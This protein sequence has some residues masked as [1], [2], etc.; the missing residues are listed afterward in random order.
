VILK[1]PP[2]KVATV[3]SFGVIY[4]LLL[5]TLATKTEASQFK[6]H[7]RYEQVISYNSGLSFDSAIPFGDIG[8]VTSRTLDSFQEEKYYILNHFSTPFSRLEVTSESELRIDI[9]LED[10][11]SEDSPI[12]IETLNTDSENT[13][14]TSMV[15]EPINQDPYYFVF[16][17]I[18]ISLPIEFVTC[19]DYT[20]SL[21]EPY[22]YIECSI[23]VS[24]DSEF[25]WGHAWIRIKNYS[26]RE[27]YVGRMLLA[28][29]ES[30]TIGKWSKKSKV[31]DPEYD[32]IWYNIE[33]FG[34]AE[35]THF[36]N[37]VYSST[38]DS[39]FSILESINA[40]ILDWEKGYFFLTD[41]C[42]HIAAGLWKIISGVALYGKI[43]PIISTG[44]ALLRFLERRYKGVSLQNDDVT[45]DVFSYE[46]VGYF[47]PSTGKFKNNL[48]LFV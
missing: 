25:F 34:R 28:P 41:N 6:E 15:L 1:K 43:P 17:A 40:Y 5:P 42:T 27:R 16:T 38:L 4:S 23:F 19:I 37:N 9:F 13:I 26:S 20:N 22:E 47:I 35:G 48:E 18:D 8:E 2:V 44:Q 7:V 36:L 11:A 30:V 24:D 29:F 46:D 45:N 3:I 33:N 12:L 31:A 14:V 39:H 10:V 21:G 32:G